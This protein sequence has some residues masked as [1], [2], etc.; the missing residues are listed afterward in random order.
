M[1]YSQEGIR[2]MQEARAKKDRNAVDNILPLLFRLLDEK[3]IEIPVKSER[4]SEMQYN[5]LWSVIEQLRSTFFIGCKTLQDALA[6]DDDSA[7]EPYNDRCM[8]RYG[9]DAKTMFNIYNTF[10]MWSIKY[11][12]HSIHH[13]EAFKNWENTPD[14]A[15]AGISFANNE[16][17]IAWVP[18]AETKT[19]KRETAK[20]CSDLLQQLMDKMGVMDD[21]VLPSRIKYGPK[22]PTREDTEIKIKTIKSYLD[23]PTFVPEPCSAKQAPHCAKFLG[24]PVEVASHL[25]KW[26]AREILGY[27]FDDYSWQNPSQ[28]ERLKKHYMEVLKPFM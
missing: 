2:K 6:F 18:A 19:A 11:S 9:Y 25:N 17:T 22:R 4:T 10:K 26:Q 15:S 20:I 1:A 28:E 5:R 16:Y 3:H 13:V 21:T 7:F 23:D 24:V 12:H 8:N 14:T 27:Y